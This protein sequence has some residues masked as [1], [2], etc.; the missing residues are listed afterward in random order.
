MKT[1]ILVWFL[2]FP[3]AGPNQDITWQTFQDG[4]LTMSACFELMGEKDVEFKQLKED[5]KVIGVQLYCKED[6][7]GLTLK[8]MGIWKQEGK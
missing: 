4:G 8:K 1:W 3:P 5:G 6:E 7:S 2:V